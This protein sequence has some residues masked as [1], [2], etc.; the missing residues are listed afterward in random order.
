MVIELRIIYN[1]INL[2][3]STKHYGFYSMLFSEATIPCL[4]RIFGNSAGLIIYI[5]I[6]AK[7]VLLK[8]GDKL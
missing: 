7:A 8:K 4:L 2:L 3:Q 6:A 1:Y 5:G